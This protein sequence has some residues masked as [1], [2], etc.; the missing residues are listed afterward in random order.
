MASSRSVG[1]F[2]YT[3]Y[4]EKYDEGMDEMKMHKLMYFSQRESL[5]LYN[6]LLFV[7]DFYGWKYGPVLKSVRTEYH[8]ERPYYGVEDD[9]LENEKVLLSAVMDRYGGL[10]SWKLSSLSHAELS[11]RKSR[12]GLQAG[13]NGEVKLDLKAMKVDAAREKALRKRQAV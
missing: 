4:A 12:N 2:L 6:R 10:S 9:L 1:A 3:L 5:M 8:K 7:E 11:W 13:E